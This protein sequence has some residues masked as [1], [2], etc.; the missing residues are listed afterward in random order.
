MALIA[1]LKVSFITKCDG[2]SPHSRFL[3]GKPLCMLDY[4]F[5]YTRG[6]KHFHE[7]LQK[8]YSS[9]E[10]LKYNLKKTLKTILIGESLTCMSHKS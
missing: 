10:L 7:F 1:H 5:L 8:C 3:L 2:I 4:K 6:L 9:P